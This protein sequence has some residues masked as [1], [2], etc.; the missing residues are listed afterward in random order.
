[1]YQ[2]PFDHSRSPGT[3]PAVPPYAEQYPLQDT[4]FAHEP[5]MMRGNHPMAYQDDTPHI[6]TS[7]LPL[8]ASPHSAST[9]RSPFSRTM[10]G[11]GGVQFVAPPIPDSPGSGVRYGEAPRR[12]PR[13]YK[14]GKKEKGE[15]ANQREEQGL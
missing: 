7:E 14:T 6:E 8:L 10:G 4:S 3:P 11:G 5:E 12:Q 13:R 2:P 9:A 1:M 15:R